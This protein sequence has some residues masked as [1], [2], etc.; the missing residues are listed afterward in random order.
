MKTLV[1][2]V[3]FVIL[4]ILRFDVVDG[5]DPDRRTNSDPGIF[6]FNSVYNNMNIDNV[7]GKRYFMAIK[8]NTIQVLYSEAQFSLEFFGKRNLSSQLQAG[9]IFPMKP[10]FFLKQFFES[11]GP[12]AT[13]TDKG[14]FSYR[15]SPFNNHGIS[16]KYELRRFGNEF[17]YAPQLMYKRVWYDEEIFSIWQGSRAIRQTESKSSGIFGLGLMIG[18]QVCYR[19]QVTDWY[20]G[21]GIRIRNSA[22][23]VLEVSDP[24]GSGSTCYP[25]RREN[26]L[27][28][29]PVINLG[30]KIGA[31]I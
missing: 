25:L 19:R 18:K 13:A 6:I 4:L 9:I 5:K 20:G 23:T 31:A 8:F 30:F 7:T 22:S 1:P 11:Y 27:S 28:V 2:L 15:N 29:Y 26:R 3:S 21:I 17:Y 16:L 24:A 10:G 14:I 12:N